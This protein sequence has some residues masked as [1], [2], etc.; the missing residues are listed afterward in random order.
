MHSSM[1][2]IS[3]A[4]RKPRPVS[5]IR[6]G[7]ATLDKFAGSKLG[8]LKAARRARHMDGGASKRPWMDFFNSLL[9]QSTRRDAPMRYDEQRVSVV[10]HGETDWS[11][12]RQHTGTTDIPL[13][14]NGR[15]AAKLLGPM[16]RITGVVRIALPASTPQASACWAITREW[17]PSNDG[18]RAM[19]RLVLL[20]RHRGSVPWRST[21]WRSATSV[22][23]SI[24]KCIDEAV[25]SGF[26]SRRSA[27]RRFECRHSENMRDILAAE[28]QGDDGARLAI[29][30]FVHR[31]VLTV[32]AYFTLLERR[33]ALVFGGGI[34]THSPDTRAR[35]GELAC[36]GRE[37]LSAAE[38][39]KRA[40]PDLYVRRTSGMRVPLKRG[41]PDRARGR[42]TAPLTD[43]SGPATETGSRRAKIHQTVT[44]RSPL[45]EWA[46]LTSRRMISRRTIDSVH[47]ATIVSGASEGVCWLKGEP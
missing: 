44:I 32:G 36:L 46:A 17:V 41:T 8:Q 35:R 22:A 24:R 28:A 27:R 38:H 6:L 47:S 42:A 31:I 33:G 7:Q 21:R 25:A 34:G 12:S 19:K 2:L 16:D 29:E 26:S 10:R 30:I 15:A 3:G 9:V 18:M 5:F 1:C 39:A 13:T 43:R 20:A 40:W 14:E 4:Q 37:S 23:S 11:I 45:R